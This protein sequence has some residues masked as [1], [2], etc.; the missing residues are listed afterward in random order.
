MDIVTSKSVDDLVKK[1]HKITLENREKLTLTG[2]GKVH[3]ANEHTISVEINGTNLII[4]GSNMQVSKLDVQTGN[5]EAI[6]AFDLI[7]Y[8]NSGTK[9]AKNI[10]NRVFK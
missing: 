7:K 8:S 5:M 10:L 1:P 6:G 3:N 2:I 4:E 9:S